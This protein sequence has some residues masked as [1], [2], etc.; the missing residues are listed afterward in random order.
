MTE[1]FVVDP[2][3]PFSHASEIA[4]RDH[5]CA[6]LDRSGFRFDLGAAEA[7]FAG[8]SMTT[9]RAIFAAEA[10]RKLGET[11]ALVT[12]AALMALV[13]RIGPTALGR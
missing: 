6:E 5:V 10:G 7:V 9:A 4:I 2:E 8:G 1:R 3:G 11:S 12:V 13:E